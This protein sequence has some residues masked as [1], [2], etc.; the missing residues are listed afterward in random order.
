MEELEKL[1]ARGLIKYIGVS[2][3]TLRHM[4]IASSAGKIDVLQPPY[5]LL[6]RNMEKDFLP[7][8]L[9]HDIGIMT[10]SSIAMGLLSGKYTEATKLEDGDIRKE[11]VPLFSGET[12]KKVL[13]DVGQL[14]S[15]AEKI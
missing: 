7:Y 12:Y 1:R 13:K 4:E 6:W 15:I 10:Y 3:F 5:S 9:E 8:C 2:N 11:K 14:K